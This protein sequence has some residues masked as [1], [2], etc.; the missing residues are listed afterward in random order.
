VNRHASHL[1]EILNS[2]RPLD[3]KFLGKIIGKGIQAGDKTGS[4]YFSSPSEIGKMMADSGVRKEKNI[5]TD[6]VTYLLTGKG[7]NRLDEREF[8]YWL[9]YHLKTCDSESLLGYSLHG[10]Y[11]GR[12]GT[13]KKETA[14]MSK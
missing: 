12:K 2:A 1:I 4:F 5:G 8:N 11:I 6:G 14:I 9:D 10:L 7:R 3:S 13:W